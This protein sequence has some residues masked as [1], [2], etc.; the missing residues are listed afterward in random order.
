MAPRGM[1]EVVFLRSPHPHALLRGIVIPPA[2][3]AQVFIAADLPGMQPIRVVTHAAGARSPAWPPPATDNV[4]YV[5]EAI[6]AC[7][8]PTRA[9]FTASIRRSDLAGTT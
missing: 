6:V 2:L 5:G 4:R 8:A 9:A 3:R 1:Q 7:V